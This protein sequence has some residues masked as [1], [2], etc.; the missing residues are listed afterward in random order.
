MPVKFP[1]PT[2]RLAV[3]GRTG[4]GKTTKAAWHLSGKNFDVQ[5]WLIVNTKGDP[6]LNEI[7]SIEGVQEID[8]SDT[9]GDKG[10]YIVSPLPHERDDLDAMFYRIW[11]KQNCGVYIDE[12]YMIEKTDGLNALL[13]QGRSRRIPMI[14]L[15]QRPAWITKFVFSEADFFS[16]FQLTRREDRKAATDI[17]PVSV[18]YR[19]APYC[20]YWYNVAENTVVQMGPVPDKAVIISTFRAKFPPEPALADAPLEPVPTRITHKRVI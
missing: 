7:A 3:L 8:V 13:T 16:L 1:G 4:S 2:D 14:I 9:P 6:L 5:P 19:L 15:S 10:L 12:G 18:D 20:S 11:E 17:V